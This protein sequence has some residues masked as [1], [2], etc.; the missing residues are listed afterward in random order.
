MQVWSGSAKS[1]SGFG[2][3]LAVPTTIGP[4]RPVPTAAG[5][6]YR[7]QP[8]TGGWVPSFG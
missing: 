6:A 5:G 4:G 8:P 7:G 3:R 1:D 2:V